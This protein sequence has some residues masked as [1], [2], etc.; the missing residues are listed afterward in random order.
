[1]A[2]EDEQSQPLSNKRPHSAVDGNE[3]D[4]ALSLQLNIKTA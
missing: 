1:M 2:A 4:G 3:D